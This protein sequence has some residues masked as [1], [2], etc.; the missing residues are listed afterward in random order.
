MMVG[1]DPDLQY[2]LITNTSLTG[3]GE[4]LFQILNTPANV[5]LT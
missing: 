5:K 1:V 2:Y 3:L 4:V